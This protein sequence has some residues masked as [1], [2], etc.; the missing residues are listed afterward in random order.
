MG[1]IVAAKSK[2]A[3]T[4]S[5]STKGSWAN[6]KILTPASAI[7]APSSDIHAFLITCI[8]GFDSYSEEEKR[9]IIDSLP[10]PYRHY[11]VDS[12]GKLECPITTDFVMTDPFLKRATSKFKS[13][14]D[15]G[16]YDPTW[17]T[18]ARK[19]MQERREG[20]FDDYLEQH[21]DE[22]FGDGTTSQQSREDVDGGGLHGDT[23]GAV[24]HFGGVV[25][26]QP[27]VN[28]DHVVDEDVG[29]SAD[30]EWSGSKVRKTKRGT[31]KAATG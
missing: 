17:Q 9:G 20:Q 21:V 18:K 31:G 25:V 5:S 28:D 4:T 24:D 14:V 7:I 3:T 8:S 19:A 1:K 23:H 27:E 11:N 15:E 16:S 22:M 6:N 26:N 30:G 12:A 2:G 29:T 13:D 10:P